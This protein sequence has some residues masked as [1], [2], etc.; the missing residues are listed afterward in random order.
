VTVTTTTPATAGTSAPGS[1][2]ADKDFWDLLGGILPDVATTVAPS[3]GID[4]RV[5]GQTVS[6]VMNIFGIGG[7][8]KAFT[9]TVPKDQALSQLKQ[10]V[11]PYLSDPTFKTA[12]RKWIQ[13][14][15]EPVQAQKQGKAYQP[16]VDL[17]KSWF[18][19]AVNWV[20]EQASKINWGQVAQVGMQALPYVTALLA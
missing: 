14:A 9:P 4:P 13:A 1:G 5:A 7:A 3:L 11:T 15:V 6:Q 18:D 8:G 2:G 17:T 19:D 20:G 10:V 16:S 12:L